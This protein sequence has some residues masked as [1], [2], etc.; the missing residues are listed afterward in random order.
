MFQLWAVE[1]GLI[2][3]PGQDGRH[4]C[5]SQNTGLES[6]NHGSFTK[7]RRREAMEAQR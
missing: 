1:R 7:R 2:G 5:F 4:L 6:L 3:S